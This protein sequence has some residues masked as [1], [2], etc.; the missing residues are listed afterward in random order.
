ML[1]KQ[2]SRE[3]RACTSSAHRSAV[4]DVTFV[5][6]DDEKLRERIPA[7]RMI[8]A[9]RSPVFEAMLFGFHADQPGLAPN[10]EIVVS[11]IHW[12]LLTVN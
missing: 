6:G 1:R 3:L 12:R 2:S 4:R 7:H 10:S 11:T 9:L 8:L 5:V